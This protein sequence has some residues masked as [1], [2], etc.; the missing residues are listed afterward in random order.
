MTGKKD[1]ST[2]QVFDHSNICVTLEMVG[3]TKF[4]S[5]KLPAMPLDSSIH[6][7]RPSRDDAHQKILAA[8]L[9][10]RISWK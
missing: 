7:S 2:I 10:M 8:H 6:N 4:E 9:D 3:S 1:C 5:A